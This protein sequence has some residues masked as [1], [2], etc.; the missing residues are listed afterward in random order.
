MPDHPSRALYDEL[1][2]RSLS[3][4]TAHAFSALEASRRFV[5]SAFLDLVA[6]RVEDVLSGAV[7]RQILNLPPRHLKSFIVSVSGIAWG[8]G[9]KPS[10]KI[11]LVSYSSDLVEKCIRQIRQILNADW[12]RALF[13]QTRLSGDK[14]TASHFET[15]KGGGVFGTTIEGALTG[16]GGDLIIID[17]PIKAGDVHSAPSRQRVHDWVSETLLSRLDDKE[18]GKVI[19]VMQRLHADDLSGALAEQGGWNHLVLPAIAVTDETIRFGYNRIFQRKQGEALFPER[20]RLDTLDAIRRE[21]GS[22]TFE[23]QYQQSPV[24]A[25][26]N[27]LKRAWI[28]FYA[29]LPEPLHTLEVIQAWD[30]GLKGGETNDYSACVTAVWIGHTCYVLDLWRGRLV[31]PDLKARVIT[32]AQQ[33]SARRILI[34]DATIGTAL[35]EELLRETGLTVIAVKPD[36]AKTD[37]IVAQSAKIESGRVLLPDQAPWLSDFDAE[38]RAF[39]RGKHDDML[40]ALAY[41]LRDHDQ[42]VLITDLPVIIPR[43]PL[44]FDW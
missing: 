21:I 4:F 23:A 10:S 20:E 35:V 38:Y 43:K 33:H 28:Q 19:L 34:E 2:R 16:L 8:L 18:T 40:D 37:R 15:S 25:D 13:P 42:R 17:D 27:L 14:N 24:P 12:Y 22:V 30:L 41:L 44:R 29:G 7:T 9:H 6:S 32:L 11:I 39:P 3:A 1:M 36:G 31:Y 26:G 5:P